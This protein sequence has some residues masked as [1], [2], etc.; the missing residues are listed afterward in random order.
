MVLVIVGILSFMMW[1][2]Q[3][4]WF[5]EDGSLTGFYGPYTFAQVASRT[6]FMLM[7]AALAGGL[8]ASRIEDQGFRH[9]MTR[10]LAKVGIPAAILGSLFFQW[11]LTTVPES[12]HLPL[13]TRLPVLMSIEF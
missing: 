1:P 2:G 3:E 10:T 11:G 13:K 8:V 9:E 4:S 7:A 5:T 6:C 12:A